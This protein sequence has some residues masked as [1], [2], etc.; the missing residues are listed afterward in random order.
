MS[1][2]PLNSLGFAK[3]PEQTRVVVAMSG[4]V[5]S[6]VCAAML[7]KEGYEVIGATLHLNS[8]APLNAT[9]KANPVH[10]DQSLRD[11]KHI[12]KQLGIEHHTVN[13]EKDFR[14]QI[15]EDFADSYLRG[16]T[17]IPCIRCNQTIKCGDLVEFAKE[18]GADCMVS[19][20]YIQSTTDDLGRTYLVRAQDVTK[21]QSYFLFAVSQDHLDFLRFPV[22]KWNKEQT[23]E[24]ARILGL[25]NANKPESQD[26]CFVPNGDYTAVVKT[27]R[28]AAEK[29]G[30]IIHTDGRTIGRH[31][32]IIHYTI[33]QRKGLGIGG[34]ISE[35]NT[36][37]Y[38]IALNPDNNQVIVGPKESLARDIID[39]KDCNWLYDTQEEAKNG[40][41]IMLKYRSVMKPVPAK[42]FTK[43]NKTAQIHL[44][45]PQ[46]GI[47]MGQAAV[48][49]IND[50]MIGGGWI[51]ATK[52]KDT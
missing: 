42:L 1:T 51:T 15:I 33:G 34:G 43:D 37:L 47:A 50:R 29:P 24:H 9:K 19:G 5:D 31:K 45:T 41:D 30:D 27:L 7:C 48:C 12:A 14:N 39:I 16:E 23:R 20:H 13:R 6:S 40:L 35:N 32:G 38:V 22:G 26:I 11:A 44:S 18:L 28:P 36:P 46:Y 10:T 17:P 21:D 3:P 4:G 25:E 49:Y 52:Q 8:T 2:T